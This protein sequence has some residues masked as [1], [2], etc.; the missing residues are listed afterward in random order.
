MK[1]EDLKFERGDTGGTAVV[2]GPQ[3]PGGMP[4]VRAMPSGHVTPWEG[5][6]EAAEDRGEYRRAAHLYARAA[7]AGDGAAAFNLARLSLRVGKIGAAGDLFRQIIERH[8]YDLEAVRGL[9]HCY[10]E[11]ADVLSALALFRAA[12][13][14]SEERFYSLHLGD[15][16]ADRTHER[17]AVRE[18]AAAEAP[19]AVEEPPHPDPLPRSTGGE[20]INGRPLRVGYVGYGL[21]D[22]VAR[23]LDPVLAAHDP[24]AVEV[25]LYG[26]PTIEQLRADQLDVAVDLLGH[27]ALGVTQPLFAA[28]PAPLCC[29]YVGYPYASGLP[30]VHRITDEVCDPQLAPDESPGAKCTEKLIRLPG[31][32]WAFKPEGTEKVSPLPADRNGFVTFGHLNRACKI[33]R[34]AARAWGAILR[35]L[36]T[37]RLLVLARGAEENAGVREL[38]VGAGVPGDRL[39]LVPETDRAGFLARMGEIDIALDPWPYNGMTTTCDLLWEGVPVVTLA[40]GGAEAARGR[41]GASLLM[42]VGLESFIARSELEYVRRAV[43]WGG[44]SI[45]HLSFMRSSLRGW[46][47]ASPLCDGAR[48]ARALEAAWRGKLMETGGHGDMETRR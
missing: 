23:F 45:E 30:W 3:N 42:S 21:I 13:S 32:C 44:S 12:R 47:A 28:R 35:G 18:S 31:C 37:A 14:T 11:G 10:L 8:P 36:P 38:L 17:W 34:E 48:V 16:V 4:V 1:F 40:S 20:G 22:T 5:Q 9:A 25:K 24:A 41:V 26:V 2:R 46:M 27:M 6:A 7:A 33:S 43:S 15:D 19:H 29:A 39:R